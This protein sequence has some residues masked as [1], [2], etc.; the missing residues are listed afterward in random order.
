MPRPG[1]RSRAAASRRPHIR[2]A[3]RLARGWRRRRPPR[4]TGLTRS[5]PARCSAAPPR[6]V[7]AGQGAA[8]AAGAAEPHADRGDPQGPLQAVGGPAGGWVG[9]RLGVCGRM[10][11]VVLAPRTRPGRGR[12]R[13]RVGGRACT[14]LGR[15]MLAAEAAARPCPRTPAGPCPPRAPASLSARQHSAAL[16]RPA[17]ARNCLTPSP[18][19]GSSLAPNPIDAHPLL[20]PPPSRRQRARASRRP[21]PH[22]PPSLPTPPAMTN[23]ADASERALAMELRGIGVGASEVPEWK[24]QV[25]ARCCWGCPLG[26]CPLGRCTRA[27][28]GVPAR[29]PPA[30][31]CRAWLPRAPARARP[32]RPTRLAPRPP[33]AARHWARRPP[34]ASAT[35]APSRTSGRACPSTSCAS[36]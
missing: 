21:R 22:P 36:S 1:S 28:G 16:H 11:S 10:G 35:T 7:G 34:L 15:I 9:G 2:V 32:A 8:R 29:E 31:G 30:R 24:Q 19:K 4:G 3:L 6:A 27:L 20:T 26:R 25:G 12:T 33:P 5:S 17:P 13:W 23:P 14:R 18:I